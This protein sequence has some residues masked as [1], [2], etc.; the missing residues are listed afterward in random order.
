MELRPQHLLL[1]RTAPAHVLDE[2]LQILLVAVD[3]L[4][5]DLPEPTDDPLA[6]EHGHAVVDDLGATRTNRLTP[7]AQPRYRDQ[8]VPVQMGS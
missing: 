8:L 1:D 4:D 5:L 2:T 7:R 6:L 3:E